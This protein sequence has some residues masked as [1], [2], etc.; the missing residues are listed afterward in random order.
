MR[1]IIYIQAGNVSN[2]IG[3]H[4]WNA[5][6]SYFTYDEDSEPLVNHDISF[7]EGLSSQATKFGSLNKH[8]DLYSDLPV[9]DQPPSEGPWN[10]PVSEYRQA[11]IEK[12]EYQLC[13]EKGEEKD[14]DEESTDDMKSLAP[15]YWSDYN[16]LF[17][18][19]RSVQ[20][21][22]DLP[23]WEA[24]KGNWNYGKIIFNR[25][26]SENQLNE[27]CLRQF[28]EESD[29]LQGF[30]TTFDNSSFGGFTT[31]FLESIRDEFNKAVVLTF[32]VLSGLDPSKI[33][34][35]DIAQL[36]TALQDAVCIRALNETAT[37]SV[38]IQLPVSWQLGDW[39]ERL[40]IDKAN[41]YQTSAVL[42]SHLESA[43]LP[44]RLKGR[45]EDLSDLCGQLNWSQSSR[46][47]HL[48]G[49]L[50]F[51]DGGDLSKRVFDFSAV[52]ESSD[53][54]VERSDKYLAQRNVTRGLSASQIFNTEG[55]FSLKS[56]LEAPYLSNVHASA[57][58]LPSSYPHIFHPLFSS[59]RPPTTRPKSAP[60]T[61]ALLS[62]LST[63]SATASV[64]QGYA[65]LAR[66]CVRRRTAASDAAGLDA[67]EM[68]E[69]EEALWTMADG[70]AG[71]G[72]E[73][74]DVGNGEEEGI[75]EV[76]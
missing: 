58:P 47:S 36:K 26:D 57:H 35:E 34:V 56:G 59:S 72:D 39:S 61:T 6:E 64:L 73:E 5:Q 41:L 66:T 2:Y 51:V 15:R 30:Q 37:Q 21:V 32:P 63:T 68:R 18:I 53:S 11:L 76:E 31:T 44:L 25:F 38:P 22:P 46:F 19:P 14:D 27:E 7:R 48:S 55:V 43:T 52:V 67:D 4:F 12:S 65:S 3:T 33:D 50:P 20:Q 29:N 62:Q 9:A 60:K 70:Y 10:G 16:R 45:Q 40:D 69:L 54:D 71:F 42:S 1:E 13:L 28:V 23:D 74:S 8:N 17:Y 24:N 75:G 49:V